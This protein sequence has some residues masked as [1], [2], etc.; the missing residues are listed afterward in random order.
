VPIEINRKLK[1]LSKPKGDGLW[2][3]APK[4]LSIVISTLEDTDKLV[5]LYCLT[6]LPILERGVALGE[7]A[8]N[9]SIL[10]SPL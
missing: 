1:D 4:Q 10:Q 3:A 2:D 5:V 8:I 9:S 6:P 7:Q